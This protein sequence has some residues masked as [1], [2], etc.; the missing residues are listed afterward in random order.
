LLTKAEARRPQR[1]PKPEERISFRTSGAHLPSFI[2]WL[3]CRAE[4][5]F[6]TITLTAR[7][8]DQAPE[9]RK[10]VVDPVPRAAAAAPL[11][12]TDQNVPKPGSFPAVLR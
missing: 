7:V 9:R 5:P 12:T 1:R 4:I 3:G 2:L 11:S 8:D 6:G 10:I